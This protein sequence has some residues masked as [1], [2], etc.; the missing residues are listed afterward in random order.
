[1]SFKIFNTS[2][3]QLLEEKSIALRYYQNYFSIEFAAPAFTGEPVKYAYMLQGLDKNWLNAGNRNFVN[4]SNLRGGNYVFKV[5]ASNSKGN[6][7]NEIA[8]INITVIPP[9]W[10]KG[11]FFFICAVVIAGAVYTLYRYRISELLKRQA[12]RNK[13]AQDLHDNMGSTL[14]SISVYSQ[15][16]K[17]Y[18]QQNKQEALEET[19]EKI[20]ETSGEMINEMGDI[21]WAINP[22]N[23]HIGTIFQR[24]ESYAKPL[25]QLKNIEFNFSYDEAIPSLNL[26][27]DKRKNFYLIFKEAVNNAVK[28]A[29]CKTLVVTVRL[30]H[31]KIHLIIQDDGKGFD[32]QQLQSALSKSLSGNGLRNM[33][34]RA[35]EMKA[36]FDINSASGKGT[37][38]SLVFDIP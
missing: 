18:N 20:G 38:I 13:I 22:R 37:C 34:M 11:W 30:E 3:P 33:Q 19:L 26:Q 5:R 23:D 27:M 31:R 17:I 2:Y 25:L 1:M 4:Y 32:M 36:Q 14:G 24:M 9:F 16:A 7:S 8:S 28:Y 12:I 6:W 35:K 15:V 10:R 29:D 21:V